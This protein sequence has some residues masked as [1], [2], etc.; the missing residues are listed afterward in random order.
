MYLDV[1]MCGKKSL[2]KGQAC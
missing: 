2:F 1:I